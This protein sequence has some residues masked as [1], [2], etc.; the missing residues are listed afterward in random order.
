[1]SWPR[2]AAAIWSTV[3]PP[4]G[5]WPSGGVTQLSQVPGLSACTGGAIAPLFSSPLT[6]VN[7]FWNG[8][9]GFRIG[10]SSKPVPSAAGVH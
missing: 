7:C 9:N 3:T 2:C 4:C 6:I 5:S 8:A 10:V 1:M